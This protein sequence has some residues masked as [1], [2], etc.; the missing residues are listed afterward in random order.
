M[1]MKMSL[2][3]QTLLG[4]LLGAVVGLIVGPK[5]EFINVV[6]EIFLRALQMPIVPLIFLSVSTA[7]AGMGD[8]RKLGSIGTK[9]IMLFMGTTIAASALGLIVAR[10]TNPGIGVDLSGLSAEEIDTSGGTSSFTDIIVSMVPN[11]VVEAMA[12]AD[13]LQII[14]FSIFTG[15][16]LL[17][18]EDK[19]R[20]KIVDLF[21]TLNKYILKVLHIV[22]LFTPYGVFVLM[23]VTAGKYGLDVAGPLGKFIGTIYLV[24]LV[25][26]IVVYFVLYYLFTRKNPITF[27]KT[28]T[29]VWV[30]SATTCSTKA[31]MPVSMQVSRDKLG[32]PED[33]NG[34]VIPVGASMNMDGNALWFGVIAVFASQLAGIDLSFSQQITAVLLGV[35]MTLGSPGIPGGIFVATTIF[36]TAIGLPIEIVGIVAGVFRIMDIG[37][38]SLNVVGTVV[39]NAI[40]GHNQGEKKKDKPDSEAVHT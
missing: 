9:L 5:I 2:A 24:I 4:M 22:L 21:E 1:K 10:F 20:G 17:M 32:V 29:P 31:T 3:T 23:A 14:V 40:L 27:F 36:L 26:L 7:I 13:M 38:T 8:L 37:I 30:T 16:A 6:G 18:L 19:D 25:H 33:I 15:V 28:I 11:N 12:S 34:F 35:L 39:V